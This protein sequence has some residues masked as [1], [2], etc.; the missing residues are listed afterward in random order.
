MEKRFFVLSIVIVI[1]FGSVHYFLSKS[2]NKDLPNPPIDETSET[3]TTS[4]QPD[5]KYCIPQNLQALLVLDPGAGNSYGTLTLKN[6]SND[7]CQIQ[8]GEYISANYDSNII[9]NIKVSHTG[10]N[11]ST[12]FLLF[13][14]QMIY[15]QVHYP[16]GPQ[17]QSI[18]LNDVQI[19]FSYQIS[20]NNK[21]IFKDEHDIAGQMLHICKSP[22]DMTEI[23]IWNMATKPISP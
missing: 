1:F 8:G 11:Q 22:S 12:S 17:C 14:N 4:K 20:P 21:V 9:K 19:T 5:T 13:P 2:T 6:I 23:K 15:S 10:Q 7:T 16:N 18:G 3:P